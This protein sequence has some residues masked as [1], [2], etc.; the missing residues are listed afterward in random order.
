MSD[1]KSSLEQYVQAISESG[2]SI[3]DYIEVGDRNLWIPTPD[4]EILID[5]ALRG[6]SLQGKRLRTRSKFVKEL[7]CQALGYPVP[8][9]F[10]KTKPRFPGQ[11]FDT[12]IQKSNNLQIW[13]DEP[14][15]TRRYVLIR[16]SSDDLITK[17]KAVTGDILAK[18]DTT[19]TLTQKYQAKL[20]TGQ[21]DAELVTN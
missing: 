2:L 19:G 21:I 3:Y 13:N 20:L 12:Y 7:I 4:L 17:V 1:H 10:K 16:V 18:L 9:S 15:A 6:I 5:L 11:F 8:K 14:E